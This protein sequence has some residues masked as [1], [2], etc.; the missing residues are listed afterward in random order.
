MQ[1]WQIGR[2][3]IMDHSTPVLA[4]IHWLPIELR[5]LLKNVLLHTSSLDLEELIAPYYPTD[6]STH[7]MM[8]SF[9]K[10]TKGRSNI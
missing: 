2:Q 3:I 4:S 9:C 1:A 8:V 5:I 7:R 10:S 6:H